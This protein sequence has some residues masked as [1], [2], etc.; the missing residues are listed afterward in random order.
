VI[1]RLPKRTPSDEEKAPQLHAELLA[2]RHSG[3]RG[4]LRL[5]RSR[6]ASNSAHRIKF[7]RQVNLKTGE[8]VPILKGTARG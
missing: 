3:L 6:Q 8:V 5:P 7:L 4:Y 2:G 1:A